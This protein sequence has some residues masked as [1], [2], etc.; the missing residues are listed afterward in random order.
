[1][2]LQNAVHVHRMLGSDLLRSAQLLPSRRSDVEK[3]A[4]APLGEREVRCGQGRT[5]KP[6]SGD[7]RSRQQEAA[8]GCG[9]I[10]RLDGAQRGRSGQIRKDLEVMLKLRLSPGVAQWLEH[11][12]VH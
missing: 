7:H 12:P 11:M 1:M 10:R 8:C 6:L 5:Q 4:G 2:L 9:F 3:A